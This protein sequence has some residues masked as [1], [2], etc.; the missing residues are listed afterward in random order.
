M[1]LPGSGESKS[2]LN[3]LSFAILKPL[4]SKRGVARVDTCSI[5]VWWGQG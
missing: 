4:G 3:H 1:I 5:V 2:V